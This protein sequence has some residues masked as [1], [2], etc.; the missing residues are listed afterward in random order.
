MK[1][2]NHEGKPDEHTEPKDDCAYVLERITDAHRKGRGPKCLIRAG[3]LYA[4]F[5]GDARF[6]G[7]F[8]GVGE[9]V[10]DLLK[11]AGL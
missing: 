6:H 8:R 9:E 5:G 7:E 2:Y 1:P 3:A 4:E 10:L 11:R